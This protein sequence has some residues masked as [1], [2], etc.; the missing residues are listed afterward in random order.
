M[1]N[2][3]VLIIGAGA[4]GLMAAYTLAKAGKKVT[5]LEACNRTGGRIRTIDNTLFFNHAE[6]GAEF[7]HG[8]LPVTLGLL[9]EAGIE[10]H[11]AG[12]NMWH[13][14]NGAFTE[15]AGMFD[16]WNLLMK[17]LNALQ[18]DMTL[19]DF[20][21]EH[22][23]DVKFDELK[24]SVRQYAAGYDTSDPKRV[25]ALA[26]RREWQNEDEDAQHRIEGG[27]CRLIQYLVTA[28][29]RAG[30]LVYLNAAVTQLNWQPGQVKAITAD[31]ETYEATKVIFAIPL[32]VWQAPAAAKGAIS[33]E[34]AIP[35]QT[36]ALQK[37]GFGAVIKVLLQFEEIFWEDTATEELAGKSLNEMA[38][39]LSD[40]AMPTWWTQAPSHAPLLTGWL[41]GPAAADWATKS[42]QD[43][44]QISLQSIANIFNRSPEW[45]KSKLV[46]WHVVNW[47][48]EP[49]IYGSY[50]YDTVHT[51]EV[52]E[53]LHNPVEN[54]IYFAGEFMYQGTAMGTV[55]AALT[56]GK[57]VANKL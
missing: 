17:K 54:T 20:L 3:D 55:E 47:T 38:F 57:E 33:F 19:D 22:F 21:D 25:S 49:Y 35:A 34:P 13:Y 56:S 44:L 41:G 39:L 27:Y 18:Q 24:E 31:G 37:L 40:E 48:A 32:G 9:K 26:L 42:E 45:L 14:S 43:I 29:K 28:F 36:E 2:A 15:G 4:A 5:V 30:G 46:A 53:L 10:Y 11:A 50:S 12:G 8:N 51:T 6:L 52:L 16:G 23:T 7:V 1:E